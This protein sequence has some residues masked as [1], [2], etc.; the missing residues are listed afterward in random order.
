VSVEFIGDGGHSLVLRDICE[1]YD[2]KIL[3]KSDNKVLAFGALSPEKL[4]AR[5][6]GAPDG[7]YPCLIHPSVYYSH[8]TRIEEGV[9]ILANAVVNRGAR[10][11]RLSIVNSGAIVEHGAI[12]GKGCHIA[13]GAV[14]LGN[15]KVGDFCFIGAN[16]VV[17][18][19]CIVPD[20]TFI[21]AQGIWKK[22][23]SK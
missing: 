7:N 10:I 23:S 17:V 13:P 6:D 2:I 9:Q 5:Y 19:E 21:K 15:A 12:I 22:K 18:Q 11:G 14:I 16:A 3:E 8:S 20:R 1:I 4:E